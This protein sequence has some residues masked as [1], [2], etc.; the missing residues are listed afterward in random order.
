MKLYTNGR[1][2]SEEVAEAIE[3]HRREHGDC[4]FEN[5]KIANFSNLDSRARTFRERVAGW[6]RSPNTYRRGTSAKLEK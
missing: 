5:E 4:Y 2:N 3:K 6:P 1:F